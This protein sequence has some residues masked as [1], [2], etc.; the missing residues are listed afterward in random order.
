MYVCM[1]VCKLELALGKLFLRYFSVTNTSIVLLHKYREIV[2]IE[3]YCCGP[4]LAATTLQNW[5]FCCSKLLLIAVH[6][7]MTQTESIL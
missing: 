6:T 5:V 2:M 3:L 1:H 7:H 4:D